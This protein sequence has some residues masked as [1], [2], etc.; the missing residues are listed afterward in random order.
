M[1]SEILPLSLRS[2]HAE[3]SRHCHDYAQ[4]VL[5]IK[6]EMELETG[7]HYGFVNT[8]TAAFIAPGESHCFSASRDNNFLVVDI[9]EENLPWQRGQI[10]AFIALTAATEKYLAFIPAYLKENTNDLF[11]DYLVQTML[12]KLLS[13][14]LRVHQD[15]RV[16]LARQWID[17][18][19]TLPVNLDNLAKNCHLST[20]QLQRRFKQEMGQ[21]LADYWR[22]KK[23]AYAQLLLSSTNL[24]IEAIAYRLGYENLAAFSRRFTQVFGLSPSQWR[25]MTL[26]AKSLPVGDKYKSSN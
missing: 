23:L 9:K 2:Y 13:P 22:G 10:P 3:K 18:H 15:Q 1:S 16:S 19:F 26:S 5:P 25:E 20:S 21:T 24:S 8:S 17:Q 6:G 11:S 14:L 4:F 12:F 7:T